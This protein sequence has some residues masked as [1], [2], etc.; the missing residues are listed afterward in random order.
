MARLGAVRAGVLEKAVCRLCF[1][2]IFLSDRFIR[3]ENFGSIE[4]PC[5]AWQIVTFT[6]FIRSENF[7]SIEGLGIY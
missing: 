3:S 6:G 2:L 5:L 4:G 1:L 7:G